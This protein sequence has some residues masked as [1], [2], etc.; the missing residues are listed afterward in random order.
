MSFLEKA[1]DVI[2]TSGKKMQVHLRHSHEEP[3]LSDDFNELG[4]WA[5]P[6][7]VLDWKKAIDLADE[8]TLKHYYRGDYRP[9]MGDSIKAYANNR[10]K[11]VW[12]HNYFTQGDG[13]DYDFLNAIEKDKRIGG[14]LLYEVDGGILH[15]GYPDNKSI[16]NK[17]NINKLHTVLQQLGKN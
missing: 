11:R 14:V 9:L 4:F 13:V 12:G 8:V 6:K 7:I 5:M 10:G 17:D 2:H 15:T 1:A 16:P 3:I